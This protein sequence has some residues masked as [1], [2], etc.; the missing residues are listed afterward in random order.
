MQRIHLPASIEA[1]SLSRTSKESKGR[2]PWSIFSLF[3]LAFAFSLW[4]WH[5]K[6]YLSLNALRKSEARHYERFS[7]P[8]VCR[9]SSEYVFIDG[10]LFQQKL[11][12]VTFIETKNMILVAL[13]F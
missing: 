8:T 10:K 4:Q 9:A 6:K 11:R 3:F 5:R 13:I 2:C 7:P 12:E 1:D